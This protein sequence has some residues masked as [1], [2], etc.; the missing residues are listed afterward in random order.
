MDS[1]DPSFEVDK[2]KLSD[3][4]QN[5]RKVASQGL[6]E[7]SIL[8]ALQYKINELIK[9]K[10]ELC[11]TQ[12]QLKIAQDT[13]KL[14]DA[15]FTLQKSE[16]E[17]QIEQLKM[18][19]QTLHE[20]LSKYEQGENNINV[21]ATVLKDVD[22]DRSQLL[23]KITEQATTISYLNAKIEKLQAK[24]AKKLQARENKISQLQSDIQMKDKSIQQLQESLTSTS[25]ILEAQS[26]KQLSTEKLDSKL[27]IAKEKLQIAKQIE[28][29]N[30]KL[31]EVL[32]HYDAEREIL[33][34][35]FHTSDPN[36]RK[37]WTNLRKK[38]KE[39]VEAVDQ[40]QK[41]LAAL[42]KTK[43]DLS[44]TQNIIKDTEQI[45]AE[46][47]RT[48][49]EL[50][51]TSQIAALY[52]QSQIEIKALQTDHER[53]EKFRRQQMARVGIARSISLAQKKILDSVNILHETLTGE[54]TTELRPL[55]LTTIL[56]QR[57]KNIAENKFEFDP[58]GASVIA[59]ARAPRTTSEVKMDAIVNRFTE[60]TSDLSVS[61]SKLAKSEE[62]ISALKEIVVKQQQASEQGYAKLKREK[63][64]SVVLKKRM[65]ELQT[66]ITELAP[67][68]KVEQMATR[69]ADLEIENDRLKAEIETLE[70]TANE[71][72][73]AASELNK[74]AMAAEVEKNGAKAEASRLKSLA[75][76]RERESEVLDARLR[77]K[78]RDMLALERFAVQAKPN[79]FNRRASLDDR[80]VPK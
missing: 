67:S 60:L 65:K 59:L 64:I 11:I 6:D 75:E 55:V 41:S 36:P 23:T 49:I 20:A 71:Y 63:E 8:D 51:N 58:E 32:T 44:T 47:Q 76:K 43:I 29:Q 78:T 40:L 42:E 48:R 52:N 21:E 56:I 80:I 73:L 3:S 13:N 69:I 31:M 2:R 57:W 79:P 17:K 72:A 46:L 68:D 9:V 7:S 25:S 35:I 28:K 10:E 27:S 33:N 16:Y 12:A 18:N 15:E 1:S 74:K 19:E 61:K 54:Q 5:V 77:E 38:A 50:E 62:R 70:A 53:N 24:I 26:Q 22:D 4:F 34:D 37:E 14:M 39:S 30:Q 45:E 66:E